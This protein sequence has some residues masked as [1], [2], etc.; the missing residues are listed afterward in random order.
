MSSWQS[1]VLLSKQCPPAL[2]GTVTI[3]KFQFTLSRLK[4][5]SGG[6]LHF[7]NVQDGLL[8]GNLRKKRKCNCEKR[9]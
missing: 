7:A 8:S 6:T 9:V 4:N 2:H 1:N 3:G 5:G